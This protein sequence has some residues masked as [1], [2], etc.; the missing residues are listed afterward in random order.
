MTDLQLQLWPL[1]VCLSEWRVRYKVDDL[2]FPPPLNAQVLIYEPIYENN[3][4]SSFLLAS[5]F[6]IGYI[7]LVFLCQQHTGLHWLESAFQRVINY[8]PEWHI[9]AL[10]FIEIVQN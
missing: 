4:E 6:E 1:F 9:C 10:S 3:R 8:Y 2:R 5:S 7:L